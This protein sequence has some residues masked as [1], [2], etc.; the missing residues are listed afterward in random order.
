MLHRPLPRK[1][2]GTAPSAG[3]TRHHS[4]H[5]PYKRCE[6]LTMAVLQNVRLAP[7]AAFELDDLPY[8]TVSDLRQPDGVRLRACTG[9]DM[10]N[11]YVAQ[12]LSCGSSRPVMCRVGCS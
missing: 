3:D 12:M 6:T 10:R 8:S 9:F 2:K 7:R 11:C 5:A 4:K 1:Q